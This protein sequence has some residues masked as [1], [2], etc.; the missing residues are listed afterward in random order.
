LLLFG[1]FPATRWPG[2]RRQAGDLG[3]DAH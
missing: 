1:E 3:I 2:I